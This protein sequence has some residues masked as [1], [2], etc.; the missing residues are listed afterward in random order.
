M[1]DLS[2]LTRD[3]THVP[4]IARWV[5]NHWT[6]RKVPSCSLSCLGSSL[7]HPLGAR[8]PRFA[9]DQ[10]YSTVTQSFL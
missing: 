3:G 5:I 1:W 8:G 2:F 9:P 6:S 7:G 10:I 4:C